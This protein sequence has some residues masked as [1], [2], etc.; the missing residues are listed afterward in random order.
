MGLLMVAALGACRDEATPPAVLQGATPLDSAEQFMVGMTTTVHE[1]GVKRAD[2][3]AD[4]AFLYDNSA[5]IEMNGVNAEFFTSTGVRDAIMT[6]KRA[7]YDVR[8]DSLQAWGDVVI[9]STD[10]R[11]L[12]TPFLRYNRVLNEISTDSVF[13]IT[14]PDRVIS[15]IGFISDP[16]LNTL[17]IKQNVS[18]SAGRVNIPDR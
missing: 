2:I 4:S 13:T 14:E 15:G 5:R 17:R 7:S 6:S 10:G 16:G 8:V 18:G 9:V 3:A 1:R 12:K 11:T